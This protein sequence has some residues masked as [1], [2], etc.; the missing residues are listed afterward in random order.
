[1]DCRL[2]VLPM[3]RHA[4]YEDGSTDAPTLIVRP[5]AGV[6]VANKR[7]GCRSTSPSSHSSRCFISQRRGCVGGLT[8][9]HVS[10]KGWGRF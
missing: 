5:R 3:A 8:H 9:R 6:R 1:M 7:R 4:A 2:K 10:S